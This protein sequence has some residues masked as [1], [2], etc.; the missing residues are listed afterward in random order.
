M[1][2]ATA[3]EVPEADAGRSLWELLRRS[4]TESAR[5]SDPRLPI[6]DSKK[7]HGLEGLTE[8]RRLTAWKLW[9]SDLSIFAGAWIGLRYL[10][11]GS[12]WASAGSA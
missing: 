8:L 11:T 10:A 6:A 4:V 1:V 5:K 9:R 2:S 3:F 12:V 7:L